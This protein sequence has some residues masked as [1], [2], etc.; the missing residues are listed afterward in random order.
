MNAPQD[1]T[2]YLDKYLNELIDFGGDLMTRA[3]VIRTMQAEG[4]DRAC[5]DRWFQGYE[6]GQRLRA[7]REGRE[8]KLILKP[9][10]R[11]RLTR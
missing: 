9:T 2:R 11:R 5:I 7:R 8:L 6:L 4:T 3:E 1:S 10:N